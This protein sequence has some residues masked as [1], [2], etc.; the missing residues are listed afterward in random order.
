MTTRREPPRM[1][2]VLSFEEHHRVRQVVTLLATV[3]RRTH[4]QKRRKT[5]KTQQTKEGIKVRLMREPC[6]FANMSYHGVIDLPLL[7][8]D[9]HDKHHNIDLRQ[10]Q[11]PHH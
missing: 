7:Q 9:Y 10:H 11:V 3:A 5:T 1:A 6:F 8:S 4:A 2:P